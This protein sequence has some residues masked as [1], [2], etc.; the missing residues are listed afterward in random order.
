MKIFETVI[1]NYG[2]CR[3]TVP[4]SFNSSHTDIRFRSKSFL[5]CMTA[6]VIDG[7]FNGPH[8]MYLLIAYIEVQ[9]GKH[10][11]R[12]GVRD[13]HREIRRCRRPT[14]RYS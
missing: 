13:D 10:P 5:P 1:K 4:I 8:E 6:Q 7:N 3:A 2:Y 12:C 14:L 11:F 9:N